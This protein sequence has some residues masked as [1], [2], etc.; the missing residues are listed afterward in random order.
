M[1]HY[2]VQASYTPEALAAMA[3]NPQNRLDVV[4]E[5]CEKGGGRL[6]TGYFAFGEYDVVAIIEMPDNASAAGLSIGSASKG[7]LRSVRTTPL[8]TPQEAM[9]A[10]QQAGNIDVQ[11]PS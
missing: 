4:A 7:H 8:L 1:P 10:M 2:L 6:E 5:A 9:E 11:P 3:R